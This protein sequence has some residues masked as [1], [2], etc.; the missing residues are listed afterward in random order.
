MWKCKGSLKISVRISGNYVSCDPRVIFRYPPE[1]PVL[2]QV[3]WWISAHLPLLSLPLC[4]SPTPSPGLDTQT[5]A[6]LKP[7]SRLTLGF[8]WTLQWISHPCCPSSNA[9]TD[10]FFFLPSLLRPLSFVAFQRSWPPCASHWFLLESGQDCPPFLCALPPRQ[11]TPP[12]IHPYKEHIIWPLMLTPWTP[13][14]YQNTVKFRHKKLKSCNKDN[15]QIYFSI[16]FVC[17]GWDKL[18]IINTL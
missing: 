15:T 9:S 3:F 13:P 5:D 17:F 10:T 4:L 11:H 18:F 2:T 8:F 16:L 12:S 7:D 6:H 14:P 1:V